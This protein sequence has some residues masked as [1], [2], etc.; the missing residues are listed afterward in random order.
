[1]NETLSNPD[2]WTWTAYAIH[3]PVMVVARDQPPLRIASVWITGRWT[4][5]DDLDKQLHANG[6]QRVE[7]E[8]WQCVDDG[9]GGEGYSAPVE[10]VGQ[11]R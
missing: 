5:L 11:H 9:T 6:W 10:W 4:V 7:G 3:E 2:I 1:M 8:E